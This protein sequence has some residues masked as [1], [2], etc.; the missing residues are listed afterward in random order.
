MGRDIA[1]LKNLAHTRVNGTREKGMD[2]GVL[3]M[4]ITIYMKVSGKMTKKMEEVN[5]DL[6]ILKNMLE[7]TKMI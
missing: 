1:F 2:S 3:K 5:K 4:L 7:N 6:K